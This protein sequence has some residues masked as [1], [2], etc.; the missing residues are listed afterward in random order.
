MSDENKP[1]VLD[2]GGKSIE[3]VGSDVMDLVTKAM[4]EVGPEMGKPLW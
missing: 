4:Q 1:V 2:V 3:E